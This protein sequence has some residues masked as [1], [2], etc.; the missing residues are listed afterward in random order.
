LLFNFFFI[1][2]TDSLQQ[3]LKDMNAIET[4]KGGKYKG[5]VRLLYYELL[6]KGVSAN[7]VQYVVKSV[8]LGLLESSLGNSFIAWAPQ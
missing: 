5:E 7:T 4:Q 2:S 6:T 8:L 1:L 3:Q